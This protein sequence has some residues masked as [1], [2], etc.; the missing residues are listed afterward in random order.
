[1]E[2]TDDPRLKMVAEMCLDTS[3]KLKEYALDN[4]DKKKARYCEECHLFVTNT[5]RELMAALQRGHVRDKFG[6]VAHIEVR[7]EDETT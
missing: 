5:L 4:M 6:K 2:V 3:S 1:M 7:E